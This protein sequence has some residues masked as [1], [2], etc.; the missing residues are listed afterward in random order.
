MIK[1]IP[2]YLW[3]I[4][5]SF[6]AFCGNS[7]QTKIDS[8]LYTC[9]QKPF[10]GNIL[11][12]QDGNILFQYS[13]GYTDFEN[14][15]ELSLDDCFVIGSI[16]KQIT[17]VLILQEYEK[18]TIQLNI[19]IEKNYLPW[20]LSQSWKKEVTIHHLLTHT[21]GIL[22][23]DKPLRFPPGTGYEYS[24]IGYE[25]LARI[26]ETVTGKTFIDLSEEL[27]E[28][29]GMHNSCHPDSGD[30]VLK[31]KGYEETVEGELVHVNE[32]IPYISAGGFVSTV[33]DL[34]LWNECLFGKELLKQPA[35][36][37]MITPWER[38]VRQHPVFGKTEY[39]YG[40]TVTK[41]DDILQVGQTGFAPGF[42]SMNFYFPEKKTGVTIL[43]NVAYEP[44]QLKNTFY[45]YTKILNIVK[46]EIKSMK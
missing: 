21:H 16:S 34:A 2:V 6:P 1:K 7:L 3:V 17:A 22:K 43:S 19:P 24:Q 44:H 33:H 35:Y 32:K 42:V 14:K 29:C 39:G 37:L 31:V 23:V 46:Q 40:V 38:A 36:E 26:L 20:L 45:Y 13:K 27:F 28:K 8:L 12:V 5:F 4:F 18:Q 30:C 9:E 25:L 15:T 41:E 11:I 10:N